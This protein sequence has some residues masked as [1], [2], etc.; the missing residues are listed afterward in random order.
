MTNTSKKNK[1]GFTQF[2]GKRRPNKKKPT[3]APYKVPFTSNSFK[4]IE[5]TYGFSRTNGVFSTTKSG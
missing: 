5:S 2:Q 1:N 4:N 3:S